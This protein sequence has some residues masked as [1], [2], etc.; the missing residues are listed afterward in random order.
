MDQSTSPTVHTASRNFPGLISMFDGGVDCLCRSAVAFVAGANALTVDEFVTRLTRQVSTD[1]GLVPASGVLKIVP[2][3]D[4]PAERGFGDLL[5]MLRAT[6][7]R[8]TGAVLAPASTDPSIQVK[9][10]LAFV[11]ECVE[12]WSYDPSSRG[13]GVVVVE[14][15]VFCDQVGITHVGRLLLEM[16]ALADQYAVAILAVDHTAADRVSAAIF[17]IDEVI[18]KTGAVA[19]EGDARDAISSDA[20]DRPQPPSS[21]AEPKKPAADAPRA[22]NP[23][24]RDLILQQLPS[25]GR[26]LRPR[27]IAQR[28]FDGKATKQQHDRTRKTL[29]NMTK[30]GTVVAES[31]EYRA[32]TRPT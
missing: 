28:L 31:G 5:S 23:H 12:A 16:R 24:A 25:E 20:A 15:D 4:R 21:A 29:Q 11:R 10:L 7:R 1:E 32:A 18:G 26:G 2:S 3:V 8:V 17:D 22:R 14:L 30:A 9:L 27:D 13:A 6:H 19:C